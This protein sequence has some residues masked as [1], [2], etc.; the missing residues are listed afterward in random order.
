MTFKLSIK[1]DTAKPGDEITRAAAL[2][3]DQVYRWFL[4]R[5]WDAS[6]PIL[7]WI[8]LNPS[9]A[10]DVADDPTIKRCMSFA[11]R[12]GYGAIVVVNLYAF[13]TSDP[14]R[15]PAHIPSRIGDRCD[16]Y[17]AN[18]VGGKLWPGRGRLVIAAWGASFNGARAHDERVAAVRKLVDGVGASLYCLDVTADGTP[19]H[20]LARGRARIPDDATPVPWPIGRAAS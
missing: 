16:E 2:S 11:R 12:L 19:K 3:A 13:R 7:V 17:I 1:G 10:D 6:L 14:W 8:M 15:M 20:P 5:D 18:V 4:V 9:T